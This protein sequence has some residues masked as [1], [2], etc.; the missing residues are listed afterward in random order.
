M[1]IPIIRGNETGT[2]TEYASIT[3]KKRETAKTVKL[4]PPPPNIPTKRERRV[5]VE[6]T[7]PSE[8]LQSRIL[9]KKTR[10][11]RL[12]GLEEAVREEKNGA[13]RMHIVARKEHHPQQLV[14]GI[15]S[16]GPKQKL[17]PRYKRS[18]HHRQKRQAA[19]DQEAWDRMNDILEHKDTVTRHNCHTYINEELELPGDVSYGVEEQFGN[20][21]RVALRL[22][23][24]LSN[25]L[26][27]IDRFEE[28]GNLRGD[29]LLNI[30]QIFGEVLANVMGD[31]KIKGSGVFFDIDKFEGPDG[32]RRQ[33]FGPFAYR[34]NE[35]TGGQEGERVNTQYR[36]VDFAGFPDNYLD[37]PWFRAVKERW[38]S[39]TYGLTKF[40]E[41]PMIRSDL[42]VRRK[43]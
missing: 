17:V 25:F 8:P 38:Q 19:F 10:L 3:R 1:V 28:Y 13:K 24:F 7:G 27:N 36:A 33:F 12:A 2:P 6:T 4:H 26:Q 16:A 20:E 35:D 41:K 15:K 18:S 43:R 23:H 32:E 9:K 34:Y 5:R 40:T 30:E 14:A 22:A 42:Q 29:A 37:Y 39:N 11:L 31:L 21:A